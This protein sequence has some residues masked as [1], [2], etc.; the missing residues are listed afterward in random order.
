MRIKAKHL[1]CVINVLTLLLILIISFI[2]DNILR[3]ILGLPVVLFFPGYALLS[4]LFPR[5]GS[6]NGIERFALSFGMS[7]AIVPL[8]GLV[9]NYTTWGIRLYPI[10]ISLFIFIFIMSVISWYRGRR[11]SPEE[12]FTLNFKVKFPSVHNLWGNQTRWGKIFTIVLVVLILGAIGTLVYVINQPRSVEKFT[13]FYVLNAEGKASNYPSTVIMGQ[14]AEVM[15]GIINHEYE[16]T[17]YRI[18]I[19][20]DGENTGEV[21]PVSLDAEEKWERKVTFTPTHTGTNQ[22]IEFLLY[23]NSAIEAEESLHLWI[24][25]Q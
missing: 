9:L 11:Y 19:V 15:L 16:T 17:A 1:L 24:E 12:S 23:K 25:V 4:A 8:I 10:I 14:S 7:I 18:E 22:K 21:G 3:V 5:E 6:L 20:I 13:E 2:P